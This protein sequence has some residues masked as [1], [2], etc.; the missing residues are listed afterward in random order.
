MAGGF[1]LYQ[2]LDGYTMNIELFAW[3]RTPSVAVPTSATVRCIVKKQCSQ[4]TNDLPLQ[5]TARDK[6]SLLDYPTGRKYPFKLTVLTLHI[7]SPRTQ[8][9]ILVN[10]HTAISRA[11]SHQITGET[12]SAYLNGIHF[13][14]LSPC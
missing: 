14:T 3:D 8:D 2:L 11:T 4:N 12:V 7:Y 9:A 10:T 5:D 6:R 1:R 13:T